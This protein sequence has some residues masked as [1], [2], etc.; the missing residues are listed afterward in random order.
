LATHHPS[1]RVDRRTTKVGV[2]TVAARRFIPYTAAY[3]AFRRFA[4][5][6]RY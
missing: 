1:S 4:E 3:A 2:F 6:W 5:R